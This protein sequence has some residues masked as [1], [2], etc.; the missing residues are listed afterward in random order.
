[1]GNNQSSD[2]RKSAPQSPAAHAQSPSAH[3]HAHASIPSSSQHH[4]NAKHS[5]DLHPTTSRTH[6][7]PKRRESVSFSAA[8][9]EKVSKASPVAPSA[10]TATAEPFKSSSTHSSATR[11]AGSGGSGSGI[12]EAGI[13]RTTTSSSAGGSRIHHTTSRSEASI[14]VPIQKEDAKMGNEQSRP[15]TAS[16][17]EPRE[18][19]KEGG[20]TLSRQ[21]TRETPPP[22]QTK[23]QAPEP[24]V[25][26]V[27][28]PSGHADHGN[29]DEN[30]PLSPLSPV[31]SASY[32][33]PVSAGFSRPPRLPLP[34]GEEEYVP[35]SPV[36]S[37][38][39]LQDPVE[40][41]DDAGRTRSMLSGT[42]VDDDVEDLEEVGLVGEAQG[43]SVPTTIE[44][45]GPGERVYV[46][47]T[48]AAWDRKYRLQKE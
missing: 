17:R 25:K 18:G 8:L 23:Q 11:V 43:P 44:W 42:T 27:D 26:P 22:I 20:G 46:T 24:T 40:T 30:T 31:Q 34:I 48:F 19:S 6:R 36:L 2:S 10:S 5:H 3:S 9:A 32:T 39:D 15:V 21:T 33:V 4:H 37:P 47:G 1:M 35:G 7:E 16:A 45:R 28:V 41:L 13:A 12:S 14:P 29:R 38:A